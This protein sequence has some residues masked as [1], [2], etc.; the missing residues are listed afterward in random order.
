MGVQPVVH[1][2]LALPELDVCTQVA[3]LKARELRAPGPRLRPAG[4]GPA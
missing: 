4:L 2:G 3:P 1:F